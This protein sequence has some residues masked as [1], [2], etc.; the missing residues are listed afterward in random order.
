MCPFVPFKA[1]HN[2]NCVHITRTWLIEARSH[3]R[4]QKCSFHDP[5]KTVSGK[6][7]KVEKLSLLD[8]FFNLESI[9]NQL[10][11]NQ[12]VVNPFAYL[13]K[14]KSKREMIF[15]LQFSPMAIRAL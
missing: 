13:V 14:L 1:S 2:I 11:P 8:R 15:S 4:F 12:F 7:T 6:I 10:K 3:S 5:K 9:K